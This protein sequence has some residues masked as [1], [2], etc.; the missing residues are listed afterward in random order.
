MPSF[1]W[2]LTAEAMPASG[3]GEDRLNP[4]THSTTCRELPSK[5]KIDFSK[6]EIFLQSYGMSNKARRIEGLIQP[7]GGGN[8]GNR[9]L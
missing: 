8:K 5:F 1:I 4:C 6:Y 2:T 3:T 7:M 9:S